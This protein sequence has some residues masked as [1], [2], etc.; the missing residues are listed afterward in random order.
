M[1]VS[2]IWKSTIYR[3]ARKREVK[4]LLD[5]QITPKGKIHWRYD[6]F[7]ADVAQTIPAVRDF[8]GNR[9]HR[10][11]ESLVTHARIH[12]QTE[13][14][15]EGFVLSS[16]NSGEHNVIKYSGYHFF[17]RCEICKTPTPIFISRVLKRCFSNFKPLTRK[18]TSGACFRLKGTNKR[19]NSNCWI[20]LH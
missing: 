18:H 7:G 12:L 1:E 5:D 11:G 13:L 3:V 16:S 2:R 14:Q 19:T 9:F 15:Q 4:T 17:N 10:R 8:S 6:C 20:T